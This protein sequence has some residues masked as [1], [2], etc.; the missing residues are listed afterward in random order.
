MIVAE[1]D[2]VA[3]LWGFGEVLKYY[4]IAWMMLAYS[5]GKE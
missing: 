3:V 1:G 4:S 5:D 2:T